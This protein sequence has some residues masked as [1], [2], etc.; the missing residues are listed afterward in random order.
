MMNILAWYGLERTK[1]DF[2][3]NYN[4]QFESVAARTRDGIALLT[5]CSYLY[6][7]YFRT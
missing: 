4:D 2:G 1:E 7:T 3:K 5:S 6:L